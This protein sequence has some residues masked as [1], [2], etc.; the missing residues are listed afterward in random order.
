MKQYM[1]IKTF[2]KKQPNR[3]NCEIC[4]LPTSTLTWLLIPVR[5]VRFGRGQRKCSKVNMRLLENFEKILS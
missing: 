3:K 2:L 1:T 4:V 5:T